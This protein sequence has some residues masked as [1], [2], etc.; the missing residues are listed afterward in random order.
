MIGAVDA[1]LDVTEKEEANGDAPT[2]TWC[3]A[4]TIPLAD[5]SLSVTRIMTDATDVYWVDLTGG[6]NTRLMRTPKAGGASVVVDLPWRIQVDDHRIYYA[7]AS[8]SGYAVWANPK[9]G[10]SLLLAD[11]LPKVTVVALDASAVYLATATMILSVPKVGGSPTIV[12]ANRSFIIFPQVADTWIYWGEWDPWSSAPRV[13]YRTPK[14]GGAVEVV[15]Q[16]ELN[17]FPFENG[18]GVGAGTL[19]WTELDNG[20]P[21]PWRLMQLVAGGAPTV[22][23]EHV[24]P[25]IALGPDAVYATSLGTTYWMILRVPFDGQPVGQFSVPSGPP[26]NLVVD[27]AGLYWGRNYELG[28]T[29]MRASCP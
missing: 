14:V 27:D 7:A 15:L 1:G 5:A 6:P 10:A 21:L 11:G 24:G 25:H 16:R 2:K 19:Y 3:T 23:A 17:A 4:Q 28:G 29:L 18:F 13:I 20:M 26:E 12:V 22:L 8:R 9:G